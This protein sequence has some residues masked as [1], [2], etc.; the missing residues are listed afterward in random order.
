MAHQVLVH[1]VGRA[2][3]KELGFSHFE[4]DDFSGI[5]IDVPPFRISRTLEE[6][7]TLMQSALD[8]CSNFVISGSMWDWDTPFKHL[9]DLAVFITTPINI[10]IERIEKRE[11]EKHG[12][13]ICINGDMFDTH[14]KF[15]EWAKAYDTDNP[16]RSL[17]L[18]EHWIETLPCPVFRINGTIPINENIVRIIEQYKHV[19]LPLVASKQK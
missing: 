5:K 2:L 3:A 4:T 14:C 13:R 19:A 10:R 12:E 16:D 18:H 17:E 1:T 7:T 15:I 9:F 11:R 8:S 6:R